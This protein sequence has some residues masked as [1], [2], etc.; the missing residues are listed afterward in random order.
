MYENSRNISN[1]SFFFYSEKKNKCIFLF[2]IQC[3]LISSLVTSLMY[4]LYY[5]TFGHY[6][7]GETQIRPSQINAE[8]LITAMIKE[9]TY[10][11]SSPTMSQ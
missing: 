8:L 7:H 2:I 6:N 1:V 5:G 10:K 3:A 4:S 9:F 11:N